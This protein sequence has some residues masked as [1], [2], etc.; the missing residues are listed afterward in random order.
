[1]KAFIT[2][3]GVQSIEEAISTEVPMVGLP[4]LADQM[5]NIRNLAKWG[6]GISLDIEKMTAFEFRKAIITV[7]TDPRFVS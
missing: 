5:K 4:I 7:S 6:I 3:G 1:M 2:Q